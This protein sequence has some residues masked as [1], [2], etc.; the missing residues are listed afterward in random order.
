MVLARAADDPRVFAG[1]LA[2]VEARL[3][4]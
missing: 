3:L 4:G 1:A 2:R